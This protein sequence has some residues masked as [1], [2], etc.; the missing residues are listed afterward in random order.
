MK[1]HKKEHT[2]TRRTFIGSSA[3]IM[4]GAL[5][6]PLSVSRSA[7][8]AGSDTLKLALIGSG[9]RGTGAAVNALLADPG[10]ELVA[11][12]DVFEEMVTS[13][14]ENLMR[15][16]R[17]KDRVNVPDEHKFVG[18]DAYKKATV[19][20]D[21]V[22]LASPPAFRPLHFEEAVNNGKHVFMEKPLATDAPGVRRILESGKVAEQKGLSVVVGLQ[23]R[24]SQR[25]RQIIN[26]IHTGRIGDIT[27]MACNYLLG[28]I[29]QLE[30]KPGDTEM[31][32]QLRNWRFFEWLWGG[33]PAGLTI[34]FEDVA[35][36]A[37]GSFPVR[38]FGTGGRAALEG[39]EQGDIYDHYY[40][41]Y[42]YEDGTRLHSRTRHIQGTW[43][44]RF[45]EFTGSKG[46]VHVPP[47]GEVD[48]KNLK[49]ETLWNHNEDDDPHPFQVE[50]DEFF[51]A[52]RNN[53]PLNDTEYSALSTMAS[54]MGRMA[55][56]SGNLV[57]WE[58]AFQSDLV[59]VPDDLAFDSD[60]PVMPKEDG[61]YHVPVP[62]DR[63]R[64]L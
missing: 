29:R 39:P 35:H 44:S 49:G 21:V 11:I 56:H 37:K 43:A 60:P 57:E 38:A 36:W 24:Y 26:E 18:L 19:L 23:Y 30:R 28:G 64:V 9:S 14:Y 25:F 47:F 8:A 3:A 59:L 12:A 33:S 32:Y 54:I 6:A 41:D 51:K 55:V 58:E 40:I 22:I 48:F 61:S 52:I 15:M 45:V 53:T 5:F 2:I 4:G 27:S 31:E 42:E 34:H 20:A 62:G 1:S 16:E 17:V 10:T 50:H 63:T 13:S 46:I 7:Y